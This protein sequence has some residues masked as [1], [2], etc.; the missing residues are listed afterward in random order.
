MSAPAL[1]P[2]RNWV[3]ADAERDQISAAGYEL[4]DTPEGQ[5]VRRSDD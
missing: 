5:K 1:G 2:R 4:L 3:E